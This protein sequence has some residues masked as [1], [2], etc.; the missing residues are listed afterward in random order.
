MYS[1]FIYL[2]CFSNS[3]QLLFSFFWWCSHMLIRMYTFHILKWIIIY[4]RY[5]A[6]GIFVP[7]ATLFLIS[8]AIFVDFFSFDYFWLVLYVCFL[9][10][11]NGQ[12]LHCSANKKNYQ[13]IHMDHK[14]LSWKNKRCILLRMKYSIWY[15]QFN[16][17]SFGFGL[18]LL[19]G[20]KINI[21]TG[22]M[23]II[24]LQKYS[25]LLCRHTYRQKIQF[26]CFFE[27]DSL[28]CCCH[29]FFYFDD[30]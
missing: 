14:G 30:C 16:G 11:E 19:F 12:Y 15:R 18:E 6:Y 13:N 3:Y 26:V 10:W 22:I 24:Q 5:F 4:L 27:R 21:C 1:V 28:I 17:I 7:H 8:N 29:L 20:T 25:S 9:L 2:F 23:R